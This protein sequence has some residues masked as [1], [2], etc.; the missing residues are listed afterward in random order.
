MPT[1]WSSSIP[2][3]AHSS[4]IPSGLVS[5]QWLIPPNSGPSFFDIRLTSVAN[6]PDSPSSSQLI[7]MLTQFTPSIGSFGLQSHATNLWHPSE[8][9]LCRISVRWLP[10]PCRPMLWCRLRERERESKRA[11]CGAQKPHADPGP[12]NFRVNSNKPP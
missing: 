7:H 5:T 1:L 4:K 12:D 2:N 10:P 9:P 3:I 8:I 6:H 11:G